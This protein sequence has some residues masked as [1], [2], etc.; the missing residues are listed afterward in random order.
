MLH[1]FAVE[2]VVPEGVLVGNPLTYHLEL[3]LCS[4]QMW[5]QSDF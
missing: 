1:D 5:T 4:L 2:T 3:E